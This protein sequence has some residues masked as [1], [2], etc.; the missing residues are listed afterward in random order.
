MGNHILVIGAGGFVGRHLVSALAKQGKHVVAVSRR[1][2]E[3]DTVDVSTIIGELNTPEQIAP[4]IADSRAVIHLASSSTPGSSAGNAL[5][6]LNDNLRPTLALLQALQ[7]RPQTELLYLSSGGSLYGDDSKEASSEM[8]SLAPRSYHGAAKVAAERFIAAWCTQYDGA[9]TILRPSNIYGP[10]Q[11][12]RAGFGIVPASFGKLTR[13]ETLTVWGGGTT[14]RD[15]LYIDD[16]MELCTAVLS[17]PMPPGASILNASSG[18]GISLNELFLAIEAVTG[19]QLKR[20]YDQSR[21]VD[22]S[23][24]V[25]DPV[26]AKNLYGWA[27]TT[28]LIEGLRK[29]WGWFSTSL[30]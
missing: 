23:R 24:V 1:P 8:S 13:G 27:P 3:F 22:S 30:P 5:A 4:L 9:A 19:Q 29:T 6:E 28:P 10:G 20:A 15:Y 21:A 14:V 17:R 18:V 12:E 11:H 7:E 16:F 2:V 25:M 26:L